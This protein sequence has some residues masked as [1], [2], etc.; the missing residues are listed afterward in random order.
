MSRLVV[1]ERWLTGG[2]GWWWRFGEAGLG[3]GQGVYPGVD[4]RGRAFHKETTWA[5]S[6]VE[7][8]YL[9]WS[10][11]PQRAAGV[12]QVS[13]LAKQE[14]TP[15]ISTAPLGAHT[16]T[17]RP[18][19]SHID[20]LSVPLLVNLAVKIHFDLN[21]NN[22]LTRLATHSHFSPKRLSSSSFLCHFF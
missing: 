11:L 6:G 4:T 16:S 3:W 5:A 13:A 1:E 10:W 15:S 21:Q 2:A 8:G 17:K 22:F 7:T 9:T 12:Q 19:T 18:P 14:T 20:R